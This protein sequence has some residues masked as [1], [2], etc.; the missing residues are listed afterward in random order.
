MALCRCK[1]HA[2]ETEK[3]K[4]SDFVKPMGYPDTSSICGHEKCNN[5]GL[6]FLDLEDVLLYKEDGQ[7]IFRYDS[8]ESKVKVEN[9]LHGLSDIN[10]M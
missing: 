6:I 8:G 7:R 4:Y 10:A 5:P 9:D 3:G 2:P 1:I